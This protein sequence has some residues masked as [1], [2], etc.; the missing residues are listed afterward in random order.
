[1]SAQKSVRQSVSLPLQIAR[2][3]R[4]FA[5]SRRTSANRILL[6]RIERGIESEKSE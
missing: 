1:M 2:K 3:V 5:Q 6:D 4:E